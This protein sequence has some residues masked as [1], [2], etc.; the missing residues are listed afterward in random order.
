MK[1]SNDWVKLR[2]C[3]KQYA[4]AAIANSW[5]GGGDPAGVAELKLH[6]RASLYELNEVLNRLEAKYQ[7]VSEKA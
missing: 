3:I 2:K 5:S 6:A 7:P 4:E 1:K